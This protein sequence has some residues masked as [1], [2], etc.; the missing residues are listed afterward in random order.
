VFVGGAS[1]LLSM[2][3]SP[4]PGDGERQI[5]FRDNYFAESLSMGG[6]FGGTA[7]A[8][9]SLTFEDNAFRVLGFGYNELD[10][11]AKE[12]TAIF[13]KNPGFAA[14]ITFRHNKHEGARKLM[15]GVF[16]ADG[17]ENVAVA[18]IAFKSETHKGHLEYWAAK[19]TV[20]DTDPPIVYQP[21]DR[22][23]VDLDMYEAIKESSGREPT[24]SPEY[25]K[26]V[27]RPVDDLRTRAPYDALGVR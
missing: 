13:S 25:W 11:A 19:A 17:N 10:P 4:Q 12:P 7:G 15:D 18:P 20:A 8:G 16:T 2:F 14:P 26:K 9:S 1:Q 24:A 5:T 23:M 6:Y 27:A 22:V 3:S 21:G